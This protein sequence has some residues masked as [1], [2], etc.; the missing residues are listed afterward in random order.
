MAP[1]AQ[2]PI[3]R[4]PLL[5]TVRIGL[6]IGM[7]GAVVLAVATMVSIPLALLSRGHILSEVAKRAGGPI[8]PEFIWVICGICVLLALTAALG[9][10][11]L[12][13]LRRIIDTVAQGDPFIPDNAVRLQRMGWLA[14]AIQLIAV[15]AGALAG[16]ASHVAHSDRFV[17]GVSLGGVF[18]AL[19][20]FVLA[21]VFRKGARMRDE[22]EGTV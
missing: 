21:R 13:E 2:S 4:D 19:I 15:P 10:L 22:L 12:R 14:V 16:W 6:S 3:R 11:F 20:L 5:A 1:P 8:P 9:F 18:L 7:I 17:I